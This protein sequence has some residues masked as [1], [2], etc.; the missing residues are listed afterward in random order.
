MV[1]F[2][3]TIANPKTGKCVQK[4]LKD[5]N[6]G[7]LIG[8]KIGEKIDG[9]TVGLEGY[10]FELT[11][12]SDF[13]GFPMR[14]DVANVIRKRI[15]AVEGVGIKKKAKGIKQRKTV[16]GNAIH[17]K[18]VQVNLK[19]LKEGTEK[20]FEE[21]AKESKDKAK[22][23]EKKADKPKEEAKPVEEK[24]E[25]PKEEKAETKPKDNKKEEV[26]DDKKTEEKK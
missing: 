4:E 17:E 7:N 11:G 5:P 13:C 8:K 24:K 10:E 23:E 6:S 15:L 19:I 12:G 18:I 2:K 3:L 16:C 22:T 1:D 25:K 9:K 14:K 21:K 26:K 20:L